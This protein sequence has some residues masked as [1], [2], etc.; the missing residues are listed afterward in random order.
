MKK[1]LPIA[2]GLAALAAAGAA[3]ALAQSVNYRVTPKQVYLYA[4]PAAARPLAI[5]PPQVVTRDG[6]IVGADPDLQI[7]SYMSRDHGG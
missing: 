5:T 7:R 3:P 4:V 2:L 6:K 1:I